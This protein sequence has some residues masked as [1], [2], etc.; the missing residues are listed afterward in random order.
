MFIELFISNLFDL[1]TFDVHALYTGQAD[2]SAAA[3]I[4]PST[5]VGT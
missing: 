1:R 2:V 3:A 4:R 5:T